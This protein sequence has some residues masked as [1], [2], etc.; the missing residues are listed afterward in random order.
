MGLLSLMTNNIQ[1]SCRLTIVSSY[2]TNWYCIFSGKNQSFTHWTTLKRII[3][4]ISR[5]LYTRI[6][7]KKS[8][9][10]SLAALSDVDWV[11]GIVDRKCQGALVNYW[12]SNLIAWGF[13]KHPT[14]SWSTIEA[15]YRSLAKATLE[16]FWINM[17]VEELNITIPS[18]LKAW[19][20][21]K[22]SI[23]LS[24][25]PT[26]YIKR[27]HIAMNYHFVWERVATKEL[28]VQYICSKD[29]KANLLTRRPFIHLS[30]KLPTKV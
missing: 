15:E 2:Y 10:N 19:C 12:G 8:L 26:R 4:Y 22:R 11:G 14:M 6:Y 25:N 5:T 24:G 23:T 16:L 3:R 13:M 20:D 18:P 7:I 30:S 29:Q 28:D 1:K 9:S 17:I 27:K 21:N